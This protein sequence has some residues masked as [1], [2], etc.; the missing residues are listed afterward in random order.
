MWVKG[1]AGVE[2]NEVAD[3]R[4]KIR[5]YGGRVAQRASI[6]TTA[7]IRQDYP[8]HS[9]PP[10][11]KWTRRQVKGLT[12]IT[13]DRGPMKHGQWIMK[14][15]DNPFCQCGEIQNAVHLMR[16]RLVVDGKGRR[17]E[18]VGEDREWC[19]AVVDFMG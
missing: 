6:L 3:K 5:A 1:H 10:H 12:F 2:G 9:K 17:P 4:A 8:V 13:T 18:Q 7:G 14:R 11:L 15:A 16:C 19:Q